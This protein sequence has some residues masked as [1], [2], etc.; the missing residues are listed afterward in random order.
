M[1]LNRRWKILY[2]IWVLKKVEYSYQWIKIR[3]LHPIWL[4]MFIVDV[5]YVWA[6]KWFINKNILKFKNDYCII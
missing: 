4:L 5:M 1:D 3:I 2:Y 6:T